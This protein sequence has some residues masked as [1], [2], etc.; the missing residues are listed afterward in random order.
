MKERKEAGTD[1]ICAKSQHFQDAG[2]TEDINSAVSAC[3]D[4]NN[5]I[6][7][8]IHVWNPDCV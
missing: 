1:S 4:T 5:S 7:V 3:L 8:W 6:Q 2:Q